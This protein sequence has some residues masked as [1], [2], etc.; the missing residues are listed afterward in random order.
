MQQDNSQKNLMNPDDEPVV[1]DPRLPAMGDQASADVMGAAEEF[2]GEML[3]SEP[4][5]ITDGEMEEYPEMEPKEPDTQAMVN[6]A[7]FA[8][9]EHGEGYLRLVVEVDEGKMR[10]IDASVVDGVLI[11]EDLTGE[12][13]YQ[14]LI[15]NRRVGAG[16]FADLSIQIGFAPPDD[17][18]IGHSQTEIT[19]FHF[20]VRIPRAEITLDELA[21]L[22][23]ELV[24]PSSTTMLSTETP[25][26]RGVS[27]SD[28]TIARG[29]EPPS[30]V[31]RMAGLNLDD[32]PEKAIESL[33]KG[34]R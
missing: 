3:M 33:Q 4:S 15:N 22:E 2:A 11:E 24:R 16:A 27:F 10:V 28:S 23:I 1:E 18:S 5:P 26:A 25:A 12:M 14:A 30:T 19:K 13:V 17:E 20:V 31:A 32:L 9:K 29:A 7:S 6:A 8:A 34:L 21:D